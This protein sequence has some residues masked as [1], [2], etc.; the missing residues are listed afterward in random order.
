MKVP[1]HCVA[2]TRDPRL[3]QRLNAFLGSRISLTWS[4]DTDAAVLAIE[5][6]ESVI[7]LL[8]L[9]TEG[10]L[11][12]LSHLAKQS[13][14]CAVVCFAEPRSR[15]AIE[16]ERIG[17]YAMQGL[18]P[19]RRELQSIIDRI[20]ERLMLAAE[21]RALQ[22]RANGPVK[23]ETPKPSAWER[24]QHSAIADVSKA[25][26]C[27]DDV[28]GLL[29]HMIET[30][31]STVVVSRAGLFARADNSDFFTL[32]AGIRCLPQTGQLRFSVKDALAR[33]LKLRAQV[34]A[35]SELEQI[36]ERSQR[37]MLLKILDDLGAEVIVPVFSQ[38]E[39]LGWLFVG[40]KA[41][42]AP[43]DTNDLEMLMLLGHKLGAPIEKALLYERAGL[44]KN[45]LQSLFDALPTAMVAVNE[46]N[47]V[48]WLNRVAEGMLDVTFEDVIGESA[49][50][51]GSRF[52]AFVRK[53]QTAT[54][55]T[56]EVSRLKSGVSVELRA[57]PL[58]V[59]TSQGLL[60]TIEDVSIAQALE[61][62][63]ERLLRAEMLA[64]MAND[65]AF[66]IRAPLT[67]IKAFVQLLPERSADQEF[68][69]KFQSIVT[70]EVARLTELSDSICTLSRLGLPR[71]ETSAKPFSIPDLIDT[72]RCLFG[73]EWDGITIEI[74]TDL[75]P[76]EGSCER[77]A[78]CICHLVSNARDATVKDTSGR[79]ALTIEKLRVSKNVQA[80]Q[81]CVSDNRP[82]RKVGA[83]VDHS[84]LGSIDSVRRADLRLSFASDIVREHAGSMEV[85]TSDNGVCVKFLL[86]INHDEETAGDR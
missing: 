21:N 43:Y 30:I 5:Q 28:A 9:R 52:A 78:E 50:I 82:V 7:V 57:Q 10:A 12:L 79:I 40:A 58:S 70:H 42:G 15:P 64:E 33:M 80:L 23:L 48:L 63:R 31:G 24:A 47:A 37:F 81:F 17:V 65:M 29:Q 67:A 53:A 73:Q 16:A 13:A 46:N 41:T 72:A 3:Q 19:G 11:D 49:E 18:E 34:V 39:L 25:F 26:Q 74:G 71:L 83:F 22:E 77:L 86:P 36:R 54:S 68:C 35:R 14:G 38:E 61:K 62:E 55:K 59:T 8:D 45:L 1:F 84:H 51:L 60:V 6:H 27:L 69:R 4:A 20:S 32:R 75:P 56:V 44:Q 76:V 66:D 85:A 2:C